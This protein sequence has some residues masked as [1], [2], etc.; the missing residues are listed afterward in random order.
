MDVVHGITI[1][2]VHSFFGTIS[3]IY[4]LKQFRISS[5]NINLRYITIIVE[6]TKL[7]EVLHLEDL[8]LESTD[9]DLVDFEYAISTSSTIKKFVFSKVYIEPFESTVNRMIRSL[10]KVYSLEQ[11][12]LVADAT[13]QHGV[14]LSGAAILVLL[15]THKSLDLTISG[16]ETNDTMK[17]I[18]G[19]KEQKDNLGNLCN[20]VS[21]CKIHSDHSLQGPIIS[22]RSVIQQ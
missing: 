5:G 16:F 13:T 1:D 10:C 7:L 4:N 8:T 11:F 20:Q 15:R 21:S 6:N 12:T 2:E 3:Q 9:D 19:R 17:K 18:L 22:D 14:S